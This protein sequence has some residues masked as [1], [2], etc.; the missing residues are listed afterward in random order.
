M[1]SS[2]HGFGPRRIQPLPLA[3]AVDLCWP[4]TQI[5][6]EYLVTSTL[7]I[8]GIL[9]LQAPPIKKNPNDI[10]YCSCIM[11]GFGIDTDLD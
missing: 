10:L 9:T 8:T 2:T 7:S 6:Q 4:I 5:V 1:L 3:T 11:L